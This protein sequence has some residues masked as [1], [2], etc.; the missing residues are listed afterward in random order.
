MS[1]FS[2]TESKI[3]IDDDDGRLI[4]FAVAIVVVVHAVVIDEGLSV[5]IF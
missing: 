4:L 1:T 2:I 3:K 5:L